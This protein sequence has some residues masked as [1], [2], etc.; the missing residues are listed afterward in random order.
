M[1]HAHLW[2]TFIKAWISYLSKLSTTIYISIKSIYN[3]MKNMRICYSLLLIAFL[4]TTASAQPGISVGNM[5]TTALKDLIVESERNLESLNSYRFTLSQ[6]QRI[7]TINLTD[8][9][10]TYRLFTIGSGAFNLTGKAMKLVTASLHYPVGQEEN[11]NTTTTEAYLLN[12]ALYTS[13]DGNWTAATL[14]LSA[15]IWSMQTRLNRSAGLTNASDIRLLGTVVID[16]EGFYV[17]EVIP[18]SSAFAS[19][20]SNLLGPGFSISSI[21]LSSFFNNTKLRYV[22]WISMSNHT[23]VAEYAQTNTT[24]APEMLGLSSKRNIEYRLDAATTL[25]LSGFNKSAIIVLPER[26]M[27]AQISPSGPAPSQG[28]PLQDPVFINSS[29]LS[30]EAQQRIW[31]AQ[32]YAFLNGGYYPYNR[33]LYSSPNMPYYSG[34]FYPYN[35]PYYSPYPMS[36]APYASAVQG[37]AA[38]AQGYAT[39]GQGYTAPASGYT[40]MT[41]SNSSLGAYLTDGSGITLYHLLSDQGGYTSKCTDATCRGGLAALL[42]SEHKCPGEHESCRF[43]NDY[44][45]WV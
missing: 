20:V 15:S 43:H 44:R 34:S 21:D 3:Y 16:G 25:R 8:G 35:I 27:R 36:Y 11:A 39:L 9:N 14:P 31:L 6:D 26:A 7:E 5:N 29:S 24:F 38:P 12:D 33:P 4:L 17:V 10:A 45:Q 40:I 32:A 37:Y 30:V 28:D 2:I 1:R 13:V 42:R 22:L 41:A 18:R 23:P 19:L